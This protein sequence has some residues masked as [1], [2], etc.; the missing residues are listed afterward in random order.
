MKRCLSVRS[1]IFLGQTKFLFEW[2]YRCSISVQHNLHNA[3][4]LVTQRECLA[5]VVLRSDS[6]PNSLR[7]NVAS[8]A[9]CLDSS[10][11]HPDRKTHIL[12]HC[13]HL[14]R[15]MWVCVCVFKSDR[16]EAYHQPSLVCCGCNETD[17]CYVTDGPGRVLISQTQWVEG[18]I[19]VTGGAKRGLTAGG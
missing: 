11:K 13:I 18:V 2:A 7:W 17:E 6:F 8:P 4:S 1:N 12:V 3:L 16:P 5:C 10:T 9:V 19:I 15:R 14:A